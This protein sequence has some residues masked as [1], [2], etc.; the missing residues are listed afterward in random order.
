MNSAPEPALTMLGITKRFPGVLALSD[1]D[2]ELHRGEILALI[3]ENGA[4]KSTLMRVLAGICS[5]DAGEVAIKGETVRLGSVR[6]ALEHGVA[7]IHQELNLAGNLDVGANILLGAEPTGPLATVKRKELMRKA[8][9]AAL[10]VGLHVP[11]S[12]IV[13]S[14]PTSQQQLVEIARAISM[15]ST[16]LVLDEPTSS[17]SDAEAQA[18]F[19]VMRRLKERGNSMIYISHRL[20][21]VESIAD[22]VVFASPWVWK[23]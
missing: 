23:P 12:A 11:M 9:E 2:I 19:T 6:D 3:G 8:S 15:D 18:L 17:L 13:E 20:G 1:V 16:I 5:P 14:L 22:R 10:S 7:V 21:E 4:G